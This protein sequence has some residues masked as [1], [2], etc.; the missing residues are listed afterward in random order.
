VGLL[1]LKQPVVRELRLLLVGARIRF[2]HGVTLDVRQCDFQVV[3][4]R[5][6]DALQSAIVETSGSVRSLLH[7]K[8]P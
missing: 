3:F 2:C 6:S 7:K 8:L 4:S 1:Q 5:S